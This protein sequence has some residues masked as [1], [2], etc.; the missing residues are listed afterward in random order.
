M[1]PMMTMM[2][3]MITMMIKQMFGNTRVLL[4]VPDLQ[5]AASTGHWIIILQWIPQWVLVVII[6]YIMIYLC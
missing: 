5:R 4:L 2:I 1:R 6:Q 3:I